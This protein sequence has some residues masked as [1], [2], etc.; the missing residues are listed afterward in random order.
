MNKK[1]AYRARLKEAKDA[2]NQAQN[3]W[4]EFMDEEEGSPALAEAYNN[5]CTAEAQ[6]REKNKDG[7]YRRI[8]ALCGEE[9]K[10]LLN[11]IVAVLDVPQWSP[12]TLEEIV[13]AIENHSGWI[14][15]CE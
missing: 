8:E 12:D 9:A 13:N 6:S 2:I 3:A 10:T 5:L 15:P 14:P 11:E 1:D 4:C 7:N